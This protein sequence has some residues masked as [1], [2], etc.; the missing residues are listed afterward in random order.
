MNQHIDTINEITSECFENAKAHGFH[1]FDE[2]D[3]AF[4][5]RTCSNIH[6]EVSEFWEAFRKHQ[7]QEPCDKAEKMEFPLTC[8]EEELADI[9]IRV[10][11]T[12]R[13]LNIDLGRAVAVKHNYNVTREYRHG[14]KAA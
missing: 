7:L 4:I 9:F 13:R 3:S 12:A 6:G 2:P 14:G 11:D 10:C 1:D 5:A 8:G